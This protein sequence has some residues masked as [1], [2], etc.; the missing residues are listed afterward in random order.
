MDLDGEGN[1]SA[2]TSEHA[3]KRTDVRQ[4]TVQGIAA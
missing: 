3:S 1:V 4:L 2:I